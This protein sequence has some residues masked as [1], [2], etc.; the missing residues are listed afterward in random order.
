[1]KMENYFLKGWDPK[2]IGLE[3]GRW[4]G[5]WVMSDQLPYKFGGPGT[6]QGGGLG[7][8]KGYGRG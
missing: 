2:L 4:S 1:M 6:E 7:S 8:R 3:E 5:L